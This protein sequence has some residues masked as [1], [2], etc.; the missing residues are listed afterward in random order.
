[1]GRTSFV[2]SMGKDITKECVV[3]DVT[4]A[5]MT[6]VKTLEERIEELERKIK[7]AEKVIGKL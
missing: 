6:Y 1:M 3:I 5:N 4:P 2:I 7:I